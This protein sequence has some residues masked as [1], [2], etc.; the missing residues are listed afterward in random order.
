MEAACAQVMSLAVTPTLMLLHKLLHK[1]LVAVAKVRR[2][3]VRQTSPSRSTAAVRARACRFR[4]MVAA[5]EKALASLH[6]LNATA[7]QALL[8]TLALLLELPRAGLEAGAVTPRRALSLGGLDVGQKRLH[9]R[10]EVGDEAPVGRHELAP[11]LAGL[12]RLRQLCVHT[13]FFSFFFFF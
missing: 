13:A 4:P 10:L 6:H 11:R 1:P 9:G 8:I 12:A 3:K 7:R 5:V 2:S